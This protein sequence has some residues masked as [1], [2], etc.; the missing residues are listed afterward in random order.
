MIYA[1]CCLC[2]WIRI[3]SSC[4]SEWNF[5]LPQTIGFTPDKHTGISLSNKTLP[6]LMWW[7][8]EH[9][10]VRML[11]LVQQQVYLWFHI[12]TFKN[13]QNCL[14]TNFQH[15]LFTIFLLIKYFAVGVNTNKCTYAAADLKKRFFW[16]ENTGFST[17]VPEGAEIKRVIV[18]LWSHWYADSH[19]SSAVPVAS[20]K[21][22][23]EYCEISMLFYN[24]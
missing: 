8:R 13:R 2:L 6:A 7:T 21:F 15:P 18:R 9:N 22:I 1:D 19:E 20:C 23:V 5:T 10:R 14:N 4:L 11:S 16:K 17:L 12:E 3:L 24:N